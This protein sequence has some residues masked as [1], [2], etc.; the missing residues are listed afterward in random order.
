MITNSDRD[1]FRKAHNAIAIEPA[2]CARNRDTLPRI[3]R[4]I[5]MYFRE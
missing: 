5:A 4:A 3:A 1:D 2:I